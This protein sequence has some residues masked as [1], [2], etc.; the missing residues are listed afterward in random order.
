V[1]LVVACAVAAALAVTRGPSPEPAPG[2]SLDRVVY[3]PGEAMQVEVRVPPAPVGEGVLYGIA[4]HL[5]RR[6]ANGTWRPA[7]DVTFGLEGRPAAVTPASPAFGWRNIGFGE[8]RT[9]PVVLPADA[10]PGSYRL[11]KDIGRVTYD[12][13]FVVRA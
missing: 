11:V 4:G 13:E 2:V 12:A 6:D 10:L 9:W 8:T 1:A 3:G 7:Y 5:E